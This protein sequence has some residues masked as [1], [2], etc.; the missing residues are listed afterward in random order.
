MNSLGKQKEKVNFI[1][2]RRDSPKTFGAWTKYVRERK[3]HVLTSH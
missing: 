1:R 3:P 2:F